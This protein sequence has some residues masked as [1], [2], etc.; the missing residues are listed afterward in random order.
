MNERLIQER[1]KCTDVVEKIRQK[2]RDNHVSKRVVWFPA[3]S[4][5]PIGPLVFKKD[6][7]PHIPFFLFGFLNF[8]V[9]QASTDFV[10]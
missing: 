6:T 5:K 2:R 4:Q 9:L 7:N 8:V 3:P 1:L 10:K